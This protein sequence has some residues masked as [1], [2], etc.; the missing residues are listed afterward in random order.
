MEKIKK[1]IITDCTKCPYVRI[2]EIVR[3]RTTGALVTQPTYRCTLIGGV[4]TL[5]IDKC[6]R[7]STLEILIWKR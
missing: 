5:N 1:N 2:F 4:F 6:W 7:K 3:A